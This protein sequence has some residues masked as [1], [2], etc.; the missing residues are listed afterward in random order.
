[1]LY[2]L[3]VFESTVRVG[4]VGMFQDPSTVGRAL[5]RQLEEIEPSE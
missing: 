1:M 3:C 2:S 4:D 5:H